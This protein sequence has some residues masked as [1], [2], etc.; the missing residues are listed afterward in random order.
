MILLFIL[1]IPHFTEYEKALNLCTVDGDRSSVLAALGMVYY[2]TQNIDAAKSSLFK[3]YN[4]QIFF[5]YLF[6]YLFI[7]LFMN[8]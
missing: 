4:I 8:F 3:R 7:Y 2:T 5:L 6:I 1:P